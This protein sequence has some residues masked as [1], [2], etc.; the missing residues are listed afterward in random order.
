M[1]HRWEPGEAGS[2]SP[3][4]GRGTAPEGAR[5]RCF[6]ILGGSQSLGGHCLSE[7]RSWRLGCCPGS[8]PRRPL[9]YGPSGLEWC[10]NWQSP[11]GHSTWSG[12]ETTAS[13]LESGKKN[14]WWGRKHPWCPCCRH[15]P[16]RR[17]PRPAHWGCDRASLVSPEKLKSMQ[18]TPQPYKHTML[19]TTPPLGPGAPEAALP[20]ARSP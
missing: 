18:N 5:H 13:P 14:K 17:R 7:Q 9:C 16:F 19:N 12:G 3:S 10:L 15:G 4:W 2:G 8:F 6:P 1:C 11:A 20:S